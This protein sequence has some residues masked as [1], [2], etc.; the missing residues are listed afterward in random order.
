MWELRDRGCCSWVH[1]GVVVLV[2]SVQVQGCISYAV[3]VGV[4]A[5][6]VAPVVAFG[7]VVPCVCRQWG[8]G[9]E[10]GRCHW[11]GGEG[12]DVGFGGSM[13]ERDWGCVGVVHACVGDLVCVVD[14]VVEVDFVVVAAAE[15]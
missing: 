12:L 11:G 4:C 7:S 5:V 1:K 13:A 15:V 14:E 2:V 9:D 3:A 10:V 8:W 6:V